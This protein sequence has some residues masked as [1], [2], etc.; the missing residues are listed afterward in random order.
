MDINF[1]IWKRQS[2][3]T[4]CLVHDFL[5]NTDDSYIVV[6]SNGM[7]NALMDMYNSLIPYKNHIISSNSLE[8]FRSRRIKHLYID[9]YF[10]IDN[11]EDILSITEPA[12]VGKEHTVD[13]FSSIDEFT[14]LD[15]FVCSLV[16]GLKSRNQSLNTVKNSIDDEYVVSEIE[17]WWNDYITEPSANFVSHPNK[18]MNEDL[19]NFVYYGER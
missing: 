17:K 1:H 15:S 13:V 11:R 14:E 10:Y 6:H 7:K 3:K 12:I 19:K 8:R 18:Y 16:R 4:K 9:E 2:G 5:K